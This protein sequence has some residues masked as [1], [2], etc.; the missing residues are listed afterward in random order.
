MLSLSAWQNVP[1][2]A[3]NLPATPRLLDRLRYVVESGRVKSAREWCKQASISPSYLG[4]V[5]SRLRAGTQDSIGAAEAAALAKA[6]DVPVHWLMFGET[7]S[8]DPTTPPLPATVVDLPDRYPQVTEFVAVM[9]EH[10]ATE[11]EATRFRSRVALL[12]SAEGPSVDELAE[13][14]RTMQ[15]EHRS[16]I[17]HATKIYQRAPV[18]GGDDP[19]GPP[20]GGASRSG[21]KG[22]R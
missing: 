17:E 21:A 9:L 6:V 1:M 20:R 2:P 4:T 7:P 14:W 22:R 15:R 8:A 5:M 13:L 3:Q 11:D 16:M 12:K 10:G 19:F 18:K